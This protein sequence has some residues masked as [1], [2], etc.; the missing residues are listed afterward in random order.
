MA[1][2]APPQVVQAQG[3]AVPVLPRLEIQ[4][5]P[6]SIRDR[7]EVDLGVMK[8]VGRNDPR[9]QVVSGE[10]SISLTLDFVA[11]EGSR[12]SV[13]AKVQWLKS[14]TYSDSGKRQSSRVKLIWGG[15]DGMYANH[16]W[17][18]AGIE[19]EFSQF[20]KPTSFYATQATVDL[21]LKLD[22]ATNWGW[23]DVLPDNILQLGQP[24]SSNDLQLGE[25]FRS[26]QDNEWL[27]IT[28]ENTF[29]RILER[30]LSNLRFTPLL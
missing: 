17:V 6:P 7:R 27:N 29:N 21:Q 2:D 22:T 12:K 9:Y 4:F 5:V 26:Q 3:R 10:T 1:V 18:I 24:G 20:N 19:T 30:A 16:T 23:S 8:I 11:D 15:V 14:L 25:A 13:Y 28:N